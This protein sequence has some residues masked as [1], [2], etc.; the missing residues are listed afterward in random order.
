MCCTTVNQTR[1]L[2]S[3]NMHFQLQ[4]LVQ[5]FFC[6]CRTEMHL[7]Q[8]YMAATT[9]L[10]YCKCS[11]VQI[12]NEQC[13]TRCRNNF[14]LSLAVGRA[15]F[16]TSIV[17]LYL[18]WFWVALVLGVAWLQYIVLIHVLCHTCSAACN[19]RCNRCMIML[20]ATWNLRICALIRFWMHYC[21][22]QILK[23]LL[24]TFCTIVACNMLCCMYSVCSSC[25]QG[26]GAAQMQILLMQQSKCIFRCKMQLFPWYFHIPCHLPFFSLAIRPCTIEDSAFTCAVNCTMS[27]LPAAELLHSV[28]FSLPPCYFGA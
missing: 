2:L 10:G 1:E 6:L 8:C 25:W 19:C 11:V 16:S 27:F 20:Y 5:F 24:R 12:C 9:F 28:L 3:T 15:Y 13:T 23:I 21:T 17:L 7:C 4:K 26:R 18:N 22:V 14:C